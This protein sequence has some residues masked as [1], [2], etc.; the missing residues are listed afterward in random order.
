[1]T[2]DE[3]SRVLAKQSFPPRAFCLLCSSATQSKGQTDRQRDRE[4]DRQT[5]RQRLLLLLARSRAGYAARMY[6]HVLIVESSTLGVPSLERIT[7]THQ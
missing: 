3:R 6:V 2:M 1:M 5:G 4:T 7:H